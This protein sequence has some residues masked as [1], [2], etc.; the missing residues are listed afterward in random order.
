M[1]VR[2]YSPLSIEECLRRINR[3]S[4]PDG[5]NDALG[6]EDVIAKVRENQFRLRKRRWY[7]HAFA[8]M[9]YCTLS[10]QG[11]GTDLV[12]KQKMHLLPKLFAIVW[13]GFTAPLCALIIIASVLEFFYDTGAVSGPP[14][15]GIL[16]PAFLIGFGVILVYTGQRLGKREMPF[17]KNYL[18]TLLNAEEAI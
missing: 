6:S 5:F 10:S 14:I 8:P 18:S 1:K 15:V 12:C 13:F 3:T 7:G 9:L 2:L 17:L 11:R 4:D 16:A